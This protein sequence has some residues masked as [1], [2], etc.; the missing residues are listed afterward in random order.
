[1][2]ERIVKPFEINEHQIGPGRPTF[3][4]AEAGVNHNGQW[5]LAKQLVEIAVDAGADAVKF[6]TFRAAQLASPSATKAKYQ[7]Q[8]TAPDESQLEMLR[9]LELSEDAFR[10]LQNHCQS[11]GIK[12]LS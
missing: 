6:Q 1:M 7:K 9:Q 5:P 4:I 2:L 3:V 12:F 11:R 8:T 10:E